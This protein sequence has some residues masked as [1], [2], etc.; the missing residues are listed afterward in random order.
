LDNERP[1]NVAIEKELLLRK[2]KEEKGKS[3]ADPMPTAGHY[4]SAATSE[5]KLLPVV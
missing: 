2:F 3:A 5:P 4:G 1:K